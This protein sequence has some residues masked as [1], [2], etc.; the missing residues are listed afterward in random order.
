MCTVKIKIT[1][2]IIIKQKWNHNHIINFLNKYRL[3][4]HFNIYMYKCYRQYVFNK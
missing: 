4:T 1:L 3:T 2:E